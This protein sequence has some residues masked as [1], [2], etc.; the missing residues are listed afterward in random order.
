MKFRRKRE[1]KEVP[2]IKTIEKVREGSKEKGK[3]SKR[4]RDRQREREREGVSKEMGSASGSYI[5]Y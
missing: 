3:R 4:E 2:G 1:G 5:S